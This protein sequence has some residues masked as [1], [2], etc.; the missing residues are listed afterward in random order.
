MML[1]KAWSKWKVFAQ[2]V[3]NFQARVILSLFYFL[4]VTPIGILIRL[5]GD[6]LRLKQYAKSYWLPKEPKENNL[7]E[8]KRQF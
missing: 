7:D 8:A 4:L 5:F 6:P 1:K 3:G 2:K